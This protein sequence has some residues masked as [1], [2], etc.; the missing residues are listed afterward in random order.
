[1][2]NENND[3]ELDENL[4]SANQ[5]ENSSKENDDD[6]GLNDFDPSKFTEVEVQKKD[7]ASDDD[8]DDSDDSSDDDGKGLDWVGYEEEEDVDDDEKG[9]SDDSVGNDDDNSDDDSGSTDDSVKS[10]LSDEQFKAF[11]DE[12][13][14][15]VKNPEEFKKAVIELEDSLEASEARI[16]E[17][18]EKLANNGVSTNDN[19]KKLENLKAKDDED[20]VKLDLEKQGFS[21]EE[22]E[23]AIDTYIDNNLLGIEAK[24]IRKTI[25]RAIVTEQKKFAQTTEQAE[26]MQQKEREESVKALSEHI[27]KTETMF[28]LKIAKDEESLSKVRKGHLSYITS[29]KYLNDITKDSESLSQSA[30]LWKNREVIMK[31]IGNENFNKGKEQILN[32]IGN[33]EVSK[34]QRYKGPDDNDGFDPKKFVFGK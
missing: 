30:W 32:D 21:A 23:E 27:N 1:M 9:G 12:I 14:L 2:G 24:K 4:E 16:K 26:A 5:E 33:P 7:N 6:S 29:G 22:I 10:S 13:G 15:E 11:A 8:S 34:T 19:V 17:L 20:L 28:G 3:A 18:E 31:A 25:D